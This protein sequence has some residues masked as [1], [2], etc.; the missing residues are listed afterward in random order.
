MSR[1]SRLAPPRMPDGKITVEAPPELV[2]SDGSNILTSLMPLVGSLGAVVMVIASNQTVTGFM[3][4]GV[5]LLSSLGFVVVNGWRQRSQRTAQILGQRREY[6]AYLGEL[7][8][9]VRTAADQQRRRGN[10]ITPDPT[11]LTYLVEDGTRVWERRPGDD[12]YLLARIGTSDQP[13]CLA[14]EAPELPPLAQLDPVAASAAHRFMLT[15]EVQ[16]ALPTTLRLDDYSRLELI[17]DDEET[18]RALARAVVTGAAALHDPDDLLIAIVVDD[19]HLAQWEWAKWLPHVGS[20]RVRDRI[21]PVR[22]I[23]SSFDELHDLLPADL[24]EYPRFSPG[25]STPRHALIVVDGVEIPAADRFV[26]ND[27]IAGITVVNLP[28]SWGALD[29]GHH[30]RV[31]VPAADAAEKQAELVR[32][33]TKSAWATPDQLSIAE[34]EATARRLLPLHTIAPEESEDDD[35]IEGQAE[36]VELLGLPDVR[37]IDFDRVWTGRPKRD[38]LRVPIGQTTTGAPIHLDIKEAAEQGMGPHGVLI[39]ATGSGKSE[40]LRTLVLALT[41]THSPEELNLVLVDFKGGATFAGMAEMPHV[42]AIITNLGSEVG[43]VDRFQD[44]LTGEVVRRQE[45]LRAAGNFANVQDYEKARKNGRTDLAPLPALLIIADEFSEL[46][47]AKPEFVD[48]FINIGRVGRSL[49]VHLLLASQ[50]LEEGK[51]RGL[52]TYLSYRVGL[53]TFSAA[54]SRTVLGVP[55]AYTLPQ[56]P[57]VGILKSDTETMTQFRAAYVSGPPKDDRGYVQPEVAAEGPAK[58]ELLPFTARALPL[59]DEEDSGEVVAVRPTRPREERSTLD[60]AVSRM[61]GRGPEAHRV[62]LPPLKIPA[63]LD[64]L[65]SD[66]V[67]DPELGL[68]SPSWRARGGL[69]VPLGMVD[70]PLEQRREQLVLSLAGAGGHVAVVGGPL[71]GK[72]TFARTLTAALA[73][74]TTPLETQFYVLDFGGGSFIGMRNL[75]HMAGVAMRTDTEAVRRSIAEVEMILNT[76]ELYFRDNGIDSMDTYRKRRAQGRVDDGWGDVF[77]IVDGWGTLRAEYEELEMRVQ[78]IA[79]R[80]L[81]FGV[82]VVITANRWLEI[83]S[84]IKD[85]LQSRVELRLG[86]PSDSE[87]DRK[88]AANVPTGLPGHSLTP[89]KLHALVALPRIDTDGD[90]GTLMDG[91]DDLVARTTAAWTGKRGPKLRL[92]PTEISLDTV[93]AEAGPN[94][95]RLL[96][97]VDETTLAPFGI[98]L[99]SESHLFLFGDSGTGKSSFLRSVAH[100]IMRTYPVGKAKI[101]LVDYRRA[102]LGEVPSE[103]LG[104]YLTSHDAATETLGQLAAF[105][106]SRLPGPDVTAEELRARSWWT[107]S[108]GFVL[109]DDYDLV[110]TSQGNPLAVMQPLLAQAADVGLHV[111]VVRR[112]GGASRALYDPILQRFT[113][114]GT[115]GILLGGSPEE[116]QLIGRVKAVP[117]APGRAQVVSRERGLFNA[118][119]A[120]VPTRDLAPGSDAS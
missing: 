77:L 117:A 86:D 38:R 50:R 39:G 112:T 52:D 19:A 65:M 106:Q 35:V 60:I 103:Y 81:G 37:D 44:A 82:H 7:R 36:L 53:R 6:L 88:L 57:G 67:A 28:T 61:E 107:G 9:T 116:G 1:S 12:D 93:R 72:S 51:L 118:Q 43:L 101:F 62:W 10:W 111:I 97:G 110:A 11:T 69:T 75:P 42:S 105:F 4:A 34:A 16:N 80:G 109:V 95:S 14:L 8:T 115:T 58:L 17:G 5:F 114:L 84:S 90:A 2:E 46:L 87:V 47:S 73:L 76:R 31:V 24:T 78:N 85:M 3:T 55:D 15:H 23:V 49:Q 92:L 91:V 94:D 26:G 41:L 74:T 25:V 79:A 13:L 40:V 104:G 54:E 119:L 98:D 113:D 89:E 48:S 63:T 20:T 64:E 70:V 100:E 59:V 30:L 108:T 21:G 27:P 45:L 68:V 18:V 96:L 22:M 120:Y 29:D 66:L 71:S 33:R 99:A 83:R 32:I 102:N 56:E